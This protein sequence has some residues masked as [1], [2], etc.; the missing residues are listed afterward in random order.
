MTIYIKRVFFTDERR[1]YYDR[2]QYDRTNT[3]GYF[4]NGYKP[5]VPLP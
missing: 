3:A 2:K 4:K 5:F 1:V